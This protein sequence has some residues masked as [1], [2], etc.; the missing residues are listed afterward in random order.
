MNDH[1]TVIKYRLFWNTFLTIL[2]NNFIIVLENTIIYNGSKCDASF[3]FLI[4][5]FYNATVLVNIEVR[6]I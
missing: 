5:K 3:L 2:K 1:V 6:A 4:Y